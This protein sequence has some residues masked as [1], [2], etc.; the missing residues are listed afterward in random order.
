MPTDLT[1][2]ELEG[3]LLSVNTKKYP[4]LVNFLTELLRQAKEENGVNTNK[5]IEKLTHELSQLQLL[6]ER[7]GP[8]QHGGAMRRWKGATRRR[9]TTSGSNRRKTRSGTR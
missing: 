5:N 9:K 2:N 7:Y 1:V 4:K 3:Y 8:K 6:N